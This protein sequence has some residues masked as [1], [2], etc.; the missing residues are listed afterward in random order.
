MHR[1][2]ILLLTIMVFLI[3]CGDSTSSTLTF[4]GESNHWSAKCVQS[5]TETWTKDSIGKLQYKTSG[6]R[7]LTLYYKGTDVSKL[8]TIKYSYDTGVAGGSGEIDLNGR[9]SLVLDSSAGEDIPIL[10]NDHI[11]DVS[12]EWNGMKE[13]IRLTSK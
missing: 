7:K 8:R 11:V 6:E 3:G 5:A 4:T 2:Y 10:H 1:F 9:T 13:N 12:V